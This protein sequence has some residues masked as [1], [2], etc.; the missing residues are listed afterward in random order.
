MNVQQSRVIDGIVH[1]DRFEEISEYVPL[2]QGGETDDFSHGSGIL[3][4][5][6]LE[7]PDDIYCKD[8]ES[9]TFVL[10]VLDYL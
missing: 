10:I 2:D 6:F 5:L 1:V 8:L 4:L 9:L 7:C 3:D